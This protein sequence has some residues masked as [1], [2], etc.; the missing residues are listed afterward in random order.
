MI[1]PNVAFVI[2]GTSYFIGLFLI[3]ATD[4]W[5]ILPF[6]FGIPLLCIIAAIRYMNEEDRQ[7]RERFRRRKREEKRR[8]M[9][10]QG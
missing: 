10:E 4:S 1:R 8:R 7:W 2:G 3:L 9:E 5:I 6:L